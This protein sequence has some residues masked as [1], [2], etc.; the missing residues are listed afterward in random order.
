[1]TE[2]CE[3]ETV[4][5]QLPLKEAIMELRIQNF[6]AEILTGYY[7]V[8]GGMEILG[9]PSIY[10]NDATFPA[11]HIVDATLTPLMTGTSVGPVKVPSLYLP[12]SEPHVVLIG[13]FSAQDAQLLANRIKLIVFTSAYV[14]RGEFHTGPETQAADLFFSV[15]GPFFPATNVDIYP[16][17]PMA[18]DLG[19]QA[20]LVYIHRDAV[21]AYH[22]F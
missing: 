2:C 8:G 11:F 3:L 1:M 16:V 9:N 6:P 5:C 7:Q 12:K 20:D 14:I 21:R 10:V 22:T 13:D 17:R 15:P 19:G 4:N 18:A